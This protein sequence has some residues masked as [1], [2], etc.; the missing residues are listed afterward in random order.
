MKEI[1]NQIDFV[2]SEEKKSYVIVW[3]SLCIDIKSCCKKQRVELTDCSIAQ[4]IHIHIACWHRIETSPHRLQQCAKLAKKAM[5]NVESRQRSHVLQIIW[6]CS[7]QNIVR[8]AQVCQQK[9]AHS[10]QRSASYHQAKM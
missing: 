9:D 7:Q 10:R 6:I 1:Q 3:S 2:F 4:R 8:I 5:A